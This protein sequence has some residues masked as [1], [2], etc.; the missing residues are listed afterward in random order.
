MAA[1]P[2][3]ATALGD[4]RFDDRLPPN[5][6][7][8]ARC[9]SAERLGDLVSRAGRDRSPRTLTPADRVTRDAL[10]DF[11]ELRA[12]RRR[13]GRRARGR[14]TRSTAPRSTFLNVPSFQPIA[15]VDGRRGPGRTLAGDGPVDRPPRR[16]P[17]GCGPRTGSSRRAALVRTASSPSSTTSSPGPIEDV[18]ALDPARGRRSVP[19]GRH[20]PGPVRRGDRA[21]R[22]RDEIRPAFAR[23]SGVPRRR[24]GARR[25][26]RRPAGPRRTC[27]A[28]RPPTPASSAAHTT[29]DLDPE[30]IH[31]DR[32]RRDRA[33]RRRVRGARRPA[34]R[35][36]DRAD[37]PR[38]AAR[39][40]GAPLRDAATRCSRRRRGV[41]R[42]GERGDPGLVRAAAR[43]R[44]ASSSSMGDHEAKPLDDRLLPPAGRRRQPAR[45]ATTSTRRSPRRGRATRP[46]RSPSTRRCRA[47]TSRSRSP[48]S[49]TACRRSGGSPGRRRSS[50]AGASTRERL[51]DEMGLYSG[52]PR[53]VRDP[54]VRRLAGVP[55]RRRHRACTPS[56]GPAARRSTSWS[57]TPRSAENNIANEVDRYLALPGPGA[58]LQDR[59]A[60]RS[61]ASATRPRPRSASAFDIRAFHDAVLG[62]GRRRAADAPRRRRGLDRADVRLTS[63]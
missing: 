14:S 4:R 56:A 60:A 46:R 48:R 11:L 28:A 51:S 5:D 58:R 2:V 53:P 52:R 3:Y 18:A 43:R 15:T 8:R 50:R 7:G 57:S 21:P 23:L 38:P 62:A 41:A 63:G 12:G 22:S 39:R 26:R 35:H 47:T 27:R 36:D 32:P 42:P 29:L 34:P 30:E 33:D 44:P 37:D 1:Q 20:G 61:C 45:A 19:A 40:P 25:P 10:V 9:A 13:G 54:V 59:P 17:A 49:S 55:A 24:A 6:A 31:R 16:E